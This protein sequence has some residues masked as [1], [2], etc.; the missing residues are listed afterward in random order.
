VNSYE[1]ER[2]DPILRALLNAYDITNSLEDEDYEWKFEF[3]SAPRMRHPNYEGVLRQTSFINGEIRKGEMEAYFVVEYISA[4]AMDPKGFSVEIDGQSH[5]YETSAVP[6]PYRR[7]LLFSEPV[8]N[9][10]FEKNYLGRVMCNLDY[11]QCRELV[12]KIVD[13]QEAIATIDFENGR[14]VETRIEDPDKKH[15]GALMKAVEAIYQEP[16]R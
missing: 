5:Q 3:Q 9:D 8:I 12:T 1:P 14:F 15:V 16:K 6:N 2:R 7:E 10:R 4:Q 11:E 13:S